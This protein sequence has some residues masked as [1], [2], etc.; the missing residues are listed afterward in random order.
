MRISMRTTCESKTDMPSFKDQSFAT[1]FQAMGD[2]CEGKFEEVWPEKWERF[3]INRPALHVPS[4][5][6]RIRHTPD[7]LTSKNL[8]ECKGLGR[9]QVLKVK[10]VEFSCWGFW[11]KVHPLFVFVWD[12]HKK[13]YTHFTYLQFVDWINAGHAT[14]ASFPEGKAYFAMPASVVFG[15]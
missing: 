5:P 2:E 12:S 9:D 11:N 7:Y 6:E 14:L 13:R 4:L 15:G 10:V 3:G 8:V 1:R